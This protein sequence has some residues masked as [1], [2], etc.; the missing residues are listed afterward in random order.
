MLCLYR[1]VVSSFGVDFSPVC[2]IVGGILGQE[3]LKAISEKDL[4]VNNVLS[5]DGHSMSATVMEF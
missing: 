4:P 1:N 2:A 5:F 3:V